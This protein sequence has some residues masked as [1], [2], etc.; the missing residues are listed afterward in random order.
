MKSIALSLILLS[1]NLWAKPNSCIQIAKS[2]TGKPIVIIAGFGGD[3]PWRATVKDLSAD[4]EV[5]IISVK[6]VS[7][8]TNC[9][10]FTVERITDDILDYITTS[11]LENPILIGHSFG[12]FLALE[13]ASANKGLFGKLVLVDSYPFML[14]MM[15]PAITPEIAE[16][17]AAIYRTQI[18]E[19]PQAHYQTFWAGNIDSM[20]TSAEEQ[21]EICK[22]ILAS[23]RHAIIDAQCAMLM[24]DQRPALPTLSCPT[25]VL[26][27]AFNYRK[28]GLDAET[29][30]LRVDEQFQGISNCTTF[31]HPSARHFIMLDDRAWLIEKI[32]QFI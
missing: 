11:S 23:D 18:C 19:L 1:I 17:Q 21:D 30:A 8:H 10:D 4:Y 29:I 31:I 27:S 6:G 22:V 14:A 20:V 9:S 32:K 25:L 24:I 26:C 5:H 28:I 15:N 12:G 2:G 7:G 16:Q 3:Y 13:L